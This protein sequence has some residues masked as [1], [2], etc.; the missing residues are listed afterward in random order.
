MKKELAQVVKLVEPV[1]TKEKVAVVKVKGKKNKKEK[2]L[3]INKKISIEE[4]KSIIDSFEKK[5]NNEHME[6]IKKMTSKYQVRYFLF[7]MNKSL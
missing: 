6:L 3:L 5:E 2:K 4:D 7:V 1:V